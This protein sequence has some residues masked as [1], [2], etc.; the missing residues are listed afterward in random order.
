MNRLSVKRQSQII[1]SLVEGNSIRAICRMTGVAKGTVLKL[2][3]DVG[4]ACYDYQ[5]K[6][7]RNLPSRRIQ[8]DEIWAFC[9]ARE[10]N[11]PKDKQGK[12]GYGDVYTW[13]ALCAVTKLV[14]SWYLGRR[15][16][17]SAIINES[18]K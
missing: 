15:D 5:D 10:K 6:A 9:Y 7:L 11:V 14:P 12:F 2:L 13:T 4:K 1:A 17:Q 3:A 18:M 16:L 8:C